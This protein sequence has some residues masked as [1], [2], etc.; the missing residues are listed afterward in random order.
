MQLI[1]ASMKKKNSKKKDHRVDQKHPGK[2]GGSGGEKKGK[3]AIS[4]C[5]AGK[6]GMEL[7]GEKTVA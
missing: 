2:E 1:I 5:A 7:R 6:K 3:K 4:I